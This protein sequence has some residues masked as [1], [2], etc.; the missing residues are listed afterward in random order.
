MNGGGDGRGRSAYPHA[1][2]IDLVEQCI[3]ERLVQFKIIIR[4][5]EIVYFFVLC[6]VLRKVPRRLLQEILTFQDLKQSLALTPWFPH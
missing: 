6:N 5:V 1:E 3:D 2:V 4:V